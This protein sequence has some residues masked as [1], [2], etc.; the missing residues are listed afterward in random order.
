MNE[1]PYAGPVMLF[2]STGAVA[3]FSFV[4][5]AKWSDNRRREREAFYKSEVLKKIA[6]MQGDTV[7]MLREQE[8]NS[9][10][11]LR[12]GIKL[13]GVT[14]AAVGIGLMPFLRAIA[15]DQPV[16]LVGLLPLLVGV[17]LLSYSYLLAPKE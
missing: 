7:A 11:R 14:T 3:L 10:R 15:P 6:E 17:A 9:L 16:Y 5:V 2:L 13:A 1:Y 8:R 4:A 12:E